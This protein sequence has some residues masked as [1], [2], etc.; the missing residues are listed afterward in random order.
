MKKLFMI[1]AMA[2]MSLTASAQVWVGGSLGFNTT[3]VDGADSGTT[4]FS[5]APEVGYS[6]GEKWDVALKL[7]YAFNDAANTNSFEITPYVRYTFCKAGNFSVF[8]D[9]GISY[10]TTHT[11]GV[12]DNANV[13]AVGFNP[14]IG[15]AVS[16]KVTL[17]AHIGDLSYAHGWQGD[18]KVNS[19]NFDIT[20]NISFGAYV[21]F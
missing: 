2:V 10:A 21:S 14:G 18:G 6:L 5:I 8:C 19:F 15:Y 3:K 4:N 7:G 12:E 11:Q 13:F 16:D 20:N 1:A 9:G 17:V